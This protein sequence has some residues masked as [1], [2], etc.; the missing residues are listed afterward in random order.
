MKKFPVFLSLILLFSLTACGGDTPPVENDPEP[1]VWEPFDYELLLTVGFSHE[2][3]AEDGTLVC[4][5]HHEIPKLLPAGELT[6]AQQVS[7]D[8]FHNAMNRILAGSRLLY[9]DLAKVALEDYDYL[10]EVGLEWT[11]YYTDEMTYTAW[12]GDL[13]VAL[14]FAGYT[15]L[16]GPHPGVGNVCYLFDLE[17]AEMV[18]FAEITDD[19]GE[20]FRTAVGKEI[21]RQIEEHGLAEQYYGD[22]A[23]T[24]MTQE[25]VEYAFRGDGLTAYFPN[26]T[27]G[28]YAAGYPSF[29]IPA[30]VYAATLN[31][32]GQTLL[33]LA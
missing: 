14:D 30:A 29:E 21:L 23:A 11:G 24:A 9:D 22:Y 20:A 7:V 4:S 18:G 12:C 8:A 6:A 1:A 13:A 2:T 28:P 10:A 15:N 33:S 32:R 3:Y 19:E 26:Y 25:E 16:G 17:Q 27:L 31:T 5:C